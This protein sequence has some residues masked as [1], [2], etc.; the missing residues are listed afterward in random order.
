MVVGTAAHCRMPFGYFLYA[1]LS[2]KVLKNPVFEANCCNQD[3]SLTAEAIVCDCLMANAA[4]V[5]LLGCR[6]HE[7]TVNELET[8][9][10]N[11]Q[12]IGEEIFVVFDR[13]HALKLPRNL[14]GDKS[15]LWSPTYG[16][17]VPCP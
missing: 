17:S 9:F 7:L 3:C 14:F 13:C 16:I 15:T 10:P 12:E 4:M 2:G 6:V 11:P 1:G 5:K 8:S